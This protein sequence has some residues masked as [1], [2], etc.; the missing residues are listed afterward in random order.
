M[1]TRWSPRTSLN[2][3]ADPPKTSPPLVTPTLSGGRPSRNSFSKA[4]F[5]FLLEASSVWL[6]GAW[7]SMMGP[8]AP[9]S[10]DSTV[11]SGLARSVVCRPYSPL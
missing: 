11:C 7:K 2:E 1:L 10:A 6:S 8:G 4:P 5:R 3:R 9:K